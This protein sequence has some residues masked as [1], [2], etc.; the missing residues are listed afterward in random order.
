MTSNEISLPTSALAPNGT[1][2]EPGSPIELQTIRGTVTRSEGG[3]TTFR[4]TEIN[5]R[6]IE[7]G[8]ENNEGDR[9]AEDGMPTRE[10]LLARAMKE[11]DEGY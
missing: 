6:P 10:G 2:P 4:L 9:P 1:P 5:G 8:D 11:D 3:T 7:G